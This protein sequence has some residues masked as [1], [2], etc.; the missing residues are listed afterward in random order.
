MRIAGI[1]S[2]TLK[3]AGGVPAAKRVLE[4]VGVFPIHRGPAPEHVGVLFH[5]HGRFIPSASRHAGTAHDRLL[6]VGVVGPEL[7]PNV[8]DNLAVPAGRSVGQFLHLLGIGLPGS[9]VRTSL[10]RRPDNELGNHRP[11]FHV[12]ACGEEDGSKAALKRFQRFGNASPQTVVVQETD[13]RSHITLPGRILCQGLIGSGHRRQAER[14]VGQLANDLLSVGYLPAVEIERGAPASLGK[15]DLPSHRTV[16]PHVSERHRRQIFGYMPEIGPAGTVLEGPVAGEIV[17]I[18]ARVGQELA[19]VRVEI[20]TLIMDRIALLAQGNAMVEGRGRPVV[21]AP[22]GRHQQYT[23]KRDSSLHSFPRGLV[24]RTPSTFTCFH[25]TNALQRHGHVRRRRI[26]VGKAR[27]Q[28]ISLAT[29]V[30]QGMGS[31]L[32]VRDSPDRL[33]LSLRRA[34]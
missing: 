27:R 4:F 23:K 34:E 20:D 19:I 33:L 30:L 8:A 3:R 18:G 1:G 21:S 32:P 22:R 12:G 5:L 17:S 9:H 14:A 31:S 15:I 29:S 11:D 7:G 2:E 24:R 6:L 26:G 25:L 28:A 16:G 10:A 13:L